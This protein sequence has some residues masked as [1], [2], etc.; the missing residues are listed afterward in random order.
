VVLR[1]Y[2][3]LGVAQVAQQLGCT[4]GSVKRQSSVALGK[5]RTVL[6]EAADLFEGTSRVDERGRP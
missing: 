5:L 2:E 6:G 4:T 3:D 1:F